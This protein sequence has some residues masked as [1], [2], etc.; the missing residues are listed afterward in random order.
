MYEF[1]QAFFFLT[2]P[3]VFFLR[4]GETSQESNCSEGAH[5]RQPWKVNVRNEAYNSIKEGQKV[6][7]MALID[8]HEPFKMDD[9]FYC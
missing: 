9:Y 7:A 3:T 1:P 4:T 2:L 5:H 6:F 8:N